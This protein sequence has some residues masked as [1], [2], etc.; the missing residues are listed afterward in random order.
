MS[1]AAGGRVTGV[2]AW[3]SSPVT[4]TVRLTLPLAPFYSASHSN[5]PGVL[6]GVWLMFVG[7]LCLLMNTAC[8]FSHTKREREML[9]RVSGKQYL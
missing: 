7:G 5:M 4:L 2:A 3:A 6:V 9:T 1:V 8:Q